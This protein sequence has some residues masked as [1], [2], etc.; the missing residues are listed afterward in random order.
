MR[1]DVAMAQEKGELIGSPTGCA[2][3][4]EG[5]WRPPGGDRGYRPDNGPDSGAP[6][7]ARREGATR[8]AHRL[9][10][11][12][13]ALRDAGVGSNR[14]LARALNERGVST[15]AGAGVWTHTSVTRLLERT[16]TRTACDVGGTSAGTPT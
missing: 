4:L 11:E 9:L 6:G 13:E 1:F 12:V 10:L 16:G 5:A 2:G 14:E 8:A 3:G 7:L 15:P